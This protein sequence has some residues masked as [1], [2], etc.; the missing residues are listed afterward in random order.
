MKA[1]GDT[2]KILK[3]GKNQRLEPTKITELKRKIAFQTSSF[4]GFQPFI[5]SGWKSLGPN[6]RDAWRPVAMK[7]SLEGWFVPQMAG[8]FF[9]WFWN[10]LSHFLGSVW[11]ISMT[12]GWKSL[13]VQKTQDQAIIDSLPTTITIGLV[14]ICAVKSR[15]T[16]HV[17]QQKTGFWTH[18]MSYRDDKNTILKKHLDTISKFSKLHFVSQ[19]YHPNAH[20]ISISNVQ[21]A[22][23]MSTW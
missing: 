16:W 11:T 2:S 4:G 9:V 13:N 15:F 7:V 17:Y 6:V 20:S 1:S 12:L 21:A 5:F 18:W 3:I 22:A 14:Y 23:S 10:V 8:C 19:E